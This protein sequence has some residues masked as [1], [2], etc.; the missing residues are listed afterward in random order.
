MC[1]LF[2]NGLSVC[3]VTE[4]DTFQKDQRPQYSDK[5]NM[6]GSVVMLMSR[7]SHSTDPQDQNRDHDPAFCKE[8]PWWQDA[9]GA[10]SPTYKQDTSC[11]KGPLTRLLWPMGPLTEGISSQKLSSWNLLR[12]AAF[13]EQPE[14]MKKSRKERIKLQSQK[15]E[16]LQVKL[17]RIHSLGQNF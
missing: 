13:L 9:G 3:L 17:S 16:C 6:S 1:P 8:L 4:F 2:T 15:M 10:A 14:G 11:T 7:T 5:D 12:Q